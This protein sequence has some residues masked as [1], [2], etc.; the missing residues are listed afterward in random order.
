MKADYQHIL[1]VDDDRRIREL[2]SGFLRAEGYLVSTASSA[3][4]ARRHM[5]WLIF[6]LLVLDVMMPGET[7]IEFAKSLR[8]ENNNV[9]VLMLSALADTENRIDGLSAGSDD[10][11]TKPFE[12]RELLLRI[13]SILRRNAPISAAEVLNEEV[14]FGPNV[15]QIDRGELRRDG[16]MIRL[17]SRERELLRQLALRASEPVP[18][19]ELMLRGAD[20]TA[21]SVDVQVNRLRRKIEPDPSN[22]QYLKTLRGAGYCLMIDR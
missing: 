1:V 22:P 18:R 20:E 17:T 6:D 8:A 4:D 21:R 14:R 2:I 7:G 10:Y 16:Q 15:F 5:H 12:P 13:Q 3:A 19:N 11:L 9:P